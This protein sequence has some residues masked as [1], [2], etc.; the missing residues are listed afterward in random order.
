M[1]N[2]VRPKANPGALVN[3]NKT[4]LEL[5]K[6]GREERRKLA[7]SLNEINNLKDQINNINNDMTEIKSL[8]L[9]VLE[10]K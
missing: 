1:T 6:K 4:E 7:S 8:L 2:L 10:S 3:V 9:K 5:Y